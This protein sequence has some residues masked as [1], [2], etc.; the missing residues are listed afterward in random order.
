MLLEWWAM[1]L[2]TLLPIFLLG[3]NFDGSTASGTIVDDGSSFDADQYLT[4]ARGP[5]DAAPD[6]RETCTTGETFCVGD[7]LETCNSTNDG[8]DPL[9]TIECDFA[10]VNDN[11]CIGTSNLSSTE[12]DLCDELNVSRRL[13]PAS[14]AV[15]AVVHNGG[16]TQIN[17]SPDCGDGS[18]TVISASAVLQNL[19]PP[20]AMFCISNLVLPA[21]ASI[22]V[23][24]NVPN[25]VALIVQSSATIA[26]QIIF[27]G[28]EFEAS[29]DPSG[30]AGAAGPGGGRGGTFN[31]GTANPIDGQGPCAG[32]GGI[33]AGQS[34]ARIG[35]GGGGGSYGGN[36]GRGGEGENNVENEKNEVAAGGNGGDSC[37]SSPGLQPLRA[38]SGGGTGGDTDGFL[39]GGWPGGGGGGALQISARD[40]INL[41]G[42]IFA[43]GG[44][45]GENPVFRDNGGGGGGGSGGAILLEA[46]ML[47]FNGS[48]EVRGG[49]GGTGGAGPGGSGGAGAEIDG[50]DGADR[51][52]SDESGG[53]G[54]GGGGRV[55]LNA[56]T[57]PTCMNVTPSNSCSAGTMPLN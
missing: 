23:A 46:P 45:G 54:G 50:S 34:G 51:Q 40:F 33:T 14:T 2:R 10:C 52:G 48:I 20:L 43:N 55:Q 35:G 41:S 39:V 18:T 31:I 29:F 4:D 12:T 22:T 1:Q 47:M 37:D 57:Q 28:S 17:C 8:A 30:T 36:G 25:A 6:A 27:S 13:T 5:A 44:D 56:A 15:I 32:S 21:G 11:M 26:G 3:C 53:G 24:D 42:S 9:E 7:N 16:N 19:S 38:G 49:N